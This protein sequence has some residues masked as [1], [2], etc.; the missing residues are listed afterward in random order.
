M[1]RILLIFLLFGCTITED[2]DKIKQRKFATSKVLFVV[3][4]DL[5]TQKASG[6]VLEIFNEDIEGIPQSLPKIIIQQTNPKKL[7]QAL[8]INQGIMGVVFISEGKKIEINTKNNDEDMLIST[9][10]WDGDISN[11]EKKLLDLRTRFI[12]Q[13]LKVV[14]EYISR[15]SNKEIEKDIK[16]KFSVNLITPTDYKI[17]KNAEDI[18]I[19]NWDHSDSDQNKTILTYSFKP[20]SDSLELEVMLKTDSIF[21]KYLKGEKESQFVRIEPNYTPVIMDNTIRG[22]WRL[23]NDF[24]GGFFIVKFY[25]VKDKVSVSA[26]VVFSPQTEKRKCV[27]EMM[28]IL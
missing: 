20:D 25:K 18:F 23:E 3:E 7:N 10:L 12:K 2:V 9:M 16:E 15:G 8:K 17:I 11:L 22:A 26:G 28:A 13:E 4:D 6:I 19:A 14:K 21:S 1:Y 24:I 27:I 5:W